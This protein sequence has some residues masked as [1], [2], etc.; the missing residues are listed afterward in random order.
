V[1]DAT[2][3]TEKAKGVLDIDDVAEVLVNIESQLVL[4]S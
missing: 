2:E 3:L 1:K 4:D